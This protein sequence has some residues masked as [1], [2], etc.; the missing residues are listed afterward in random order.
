MKQRTRNHTGNKPS[1]VVTVTYM[2]EIIE[3][4]ISPSNSP[5]ISKLIGAQMLSINGLIFAYAHPPMY[6]KLS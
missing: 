5:Q 3:P 6:L 2:S 1:D 4:S